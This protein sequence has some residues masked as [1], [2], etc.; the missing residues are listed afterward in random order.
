MTD[1]VARS[2]SR[3]GLWAVACAVSLAALAIPVVGPRLALGS[4]PALGSLVYLG[5]QA[6]LVHR[7]PHRDVL[8]GLAQRDAIDHAAA[9]C[10]YVI[11]LDDFKLIEEQL[12]RQAIEVVIKICADR[13]RRSVAP[14]DLLVRLEGPCFAVADTGDQPQ[15]LETALQYAARLQQALS[16]PLEVDGTFL[17]LSASVGFCLASRLAASDPPDLLRAAMSAMI[18]AARCGPGA[19]RSYSAIM[20]Q[21][22]AS[23]KSLTREVSDAMALG[24][25]RAYFQP[26]VATR[27]GEVT[28]FETLARWDHPER[29]LIPPIEFMP[30]LEQAGQ[31]HRLAN[32]MVQDALSALRDWDDE[33]LSVPR[34]GVNFSTEELRDPHLVERIEWEIDRFDLKPERLAIEVLE[35]V[36]AD[37]SEDAVIRNLA[38]LAELGCCLDLDDFGTGHASITNIRRFSIERIKI[39]R[40]FVTRIDADPEQ[41]NMVGAILTMADRLGLDTLA[42]GVESDAELA[43][44]R[45]LGCAHV[46]GFGIAR[47]M[48]RADADIWLR[49]RQHPTVEPL[50]LPRRA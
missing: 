37:R 12:D 32:I 42:E 25:L 19:I 47:P 5:L 31:M 4:L 48:P 35:T 30:A 41:Q 6:I 46:Q 43:M 45:R 1:R 50:N 26:Q 20:R 24:Q 13:L 39:D 29:G 10:T 11:E 34:V 17:Y 44:L 18:E 7:R 14:T 28:G 8:T 9:R 49:A 3:P 33:G 36:V 40:S 15:S 27:T 2:P 22:I 23:R 21:R 16:E 38:G